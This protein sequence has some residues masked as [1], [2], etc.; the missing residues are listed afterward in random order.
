MLSDSQLPM[1]VLRLLK[2]QMHCMNNAVQEPFW[3]SADSN[4]IFKEDLILSVSLFFQQYV[5]NFLIFAVH[6]SS[7]TTMTPKWF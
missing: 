1:Y 4:V 7:T 6:F 3:G 2:M 5:I